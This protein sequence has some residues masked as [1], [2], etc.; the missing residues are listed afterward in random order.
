MMYTMYYLI[1][2]YMLYDVYY[3]VY[4]IYY[5]LTSVRRR[6]DLSKYSSLHPFIQI[7]ICQLRIRGAQFGMDNQSINS[8]EKV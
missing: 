2:Y 6:Q 7:R 1:I 4:S 5:I 3:I 8:I